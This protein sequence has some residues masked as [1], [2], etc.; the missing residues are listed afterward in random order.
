MPVLLPTQGVEKC[1]WF[2]SQAVLLTYQGFAQDI[3]DNLLQNCVMHSFVHGIL[4]IS[5]VSLFEELV[6]E[7]VALGVGIVNLGCAAP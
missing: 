2:R 6:S 1:F 4:L 7:L 3:E 5:G